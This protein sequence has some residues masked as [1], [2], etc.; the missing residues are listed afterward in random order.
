MPNP[1]CVDL[2]LGGELSAALARAGRIGIDTEFMRESTFFSQLCLLQV[3]AGDSIYCVDPLAGTDSD[4]GSSWSKLLT[5]PWV[6]HSGRQDIEVV[7]QTAG[8]MPTCVFDTQIAAGLLGYQP[9]LGYASLVAELFDVQLAK[10]H[11]RADWSKRPLTSDL[12]EYA[13]E[14][15]LY[16]LPAHDIL[17]RR[18]A[19][20]GRI[21]WAEQDSA[22]LLQPALYD[23]NPATAVEKLRGARNLQG[24]ARNISVR[25]AAW[26]EQEALRSNRPRQWIAKDSVLLDIASSRPESAEEL[27]AIHGMS[28]RTVRRAS[29]AILSAVQS[30]TTDAHDYQAPDRPD[31]EQKALL[32]KL[33]KYTS[34]VAHELGIASE[35]IAPKK[36]LSAA[37]SGTRS[38]RLF[39]GWRAEIIGDKILDLLDS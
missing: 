34:G 14:D 8:V 1:V 18:L 15:V 30:G 3:S 36:D 4:T 23:I 26:R 13:A 35:I 25:L 21:E 5:V 2:S 28:E 27:A 7:Y 11:T 33:H 9:Q 10:L 16:L 24:V 32:K 6:L 20:L 17:G 37:I 29:S 31:E 22:E 12:L 39:R 19:E 38:G